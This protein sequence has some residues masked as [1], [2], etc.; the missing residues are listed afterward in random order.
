MNEKS[1]DNNQE[2]ENKATGKDSEKE[3][4]NSVRNEGK[5][6]EIQVKN[7]KSHPR[8]QSI[9]QR[10]GKKFVKTTKVVRSI[11]R[12]SKQLNPI[13]DNSLKSADTSSKVNPPIVIPKETVNSESNQPDKSKQSTVGNNK[14]SEQQQLSTN[15]NDKESSIISDDK[16]EL[17]VNTSNDPNVNPNVNPNDN[18]NPNRAKFRPKFKTVAL[19]SVAGKKGNLVKGKKPMEPKKPPK[20][21]P[22]RFIEL[23]KKGSWNRVIELMDEYPSENNNIGLSSVDP[24]TGYSPI[25]FAVKSSRA[26]VLERMIK[27][28]FHINT[29]T[30]V[31]SLIKFY[32]TLIKMTFK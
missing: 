4:V 2:S 22:E 20:P 11:V 16:S 17:K 8:K 21:G 29:Q 31:S 9:D 27:Y 23:C 6:S 14:Q 10:K 5:S 12:T 26:D 1:V 15:G 13:G 32:F 24:V 7:V 18:V 30:E 25:M 28:G 3:N 19:L